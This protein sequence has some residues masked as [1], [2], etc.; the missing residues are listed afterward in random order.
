VIAQKHADQYA[1]GQVL[2]ALGEVARVLDEPSVAHQYYV[3]SLHIRRELGDTRG[4]AMCL[5]NLGHVLVA[6]DELR[7]AQETLVESL[8]LLEELEHEY[9]QAVCVSALA[10]VA[11]ADR[12]PAV[13]ARLLGAAQAALERVG[14]SLEPAD[15]RACAHTLALAGEALGSQFEVEFAT[16]RG[17]SLVDAAALLEV[18]AVTNEPG[19]EPVSSSVSVLSPREREVVTLIARGCTSEAI[20]EALV[21]SRRTAD[22]HA[23]HIR[24]KLGLRSR[25]EIAAWAIQNG[26]G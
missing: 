19:S 25:A 1:L 24:D 13:A 26:L 20:A 10:A 12:Q 11:A 7:H 17:L 18:G 16:G 14:N 23:A 4:V 22:T 6:E 5:T 9:G 3:R 21:I 2:N 8:G 15:Q